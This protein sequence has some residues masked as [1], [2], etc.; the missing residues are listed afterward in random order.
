MSIWWT[1][2]YISYDEA[3]K[4][5]EDYEK[6]IC[7]YGNVTDWENSLR[8]KKDDLDYKN[9]VQRLLKEID[10]KRACQHEAEELIRDSS[11]PEWYS[12]RYLTRDE[13]VRIV[14]TNREKMGLPPYPAKDDTEGMLCY[15]AILD[16]W[17]VMH[18]NQAY[19]IK[20]L[21]DCEQAR[22]KKAWA[23]LPWSV[24]AKEFLFDA[25]VYLLWFVLAVITLP[26][27]IIYRILLLKS[28]S[29]RTICFEDDFGGYYKWCKA[30]KH[31]FHK[32]L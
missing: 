12:F 2:S 8:G 17:V 18:P 5:V 14:V 20:V 27:S 1:P 30:E 26:I 19:G 6:G 28:Q 22:K 4:I 13:I 3:D 11:K 16:K 7:I 21:I 24:R 32:Y 10:E 9:P 29:D 31:K 15:N 23:A 25:G